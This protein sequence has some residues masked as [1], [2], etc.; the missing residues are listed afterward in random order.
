MIESVIVTFQD[1]VEEGRR[2]LNEEHD[3]MTSKELNDKD[4]IQ[5]CR[6]YQFWI[7]GYLY[8]ASRSFFPIRYGM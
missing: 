6:Y 5:T 1:G 3:P 8:I 4:L 2:F 7:R